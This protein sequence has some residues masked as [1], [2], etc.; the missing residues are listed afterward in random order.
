MYRHTIL[1]SIYGDSVKIA[2]NY[3]YTLDMITYNTKASSTIKDT[4]SSSFALA[5]NGRGTLI[6]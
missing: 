6:T 3:N 2:H 5:I 4:G 1:F